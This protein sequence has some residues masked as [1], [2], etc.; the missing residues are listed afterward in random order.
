MNKHL[1][2]STSEPYDNAKLSGQNRTQRDKWAWKN[3][4]TWGYT[5]LGNFELSAIILVR[6]GETEIKV[7][8]LQKGKLKGEK[9]K[10]DSP[11]HNLSLKGLYSRWGWSGSR[12]AL[13]QLNIILYLSVPCREPQFRSCGLALPSETWKKQLISLWRKVPVSKVSKLLII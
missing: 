6:A 11:H 2:K 13:V 5:T 3:V 7:L 12:R 9:K 8:S 10:K 1:L 4:L